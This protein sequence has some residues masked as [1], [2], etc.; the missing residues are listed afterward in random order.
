MKKGGGRKEEEQ[1]SSSSKLFNL[2]TIYFNFLRN[3]VFKLRNKIQDKE[4]TREIKTK[5]IN[6]IL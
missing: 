2:S 6:Q 4:K 5:V 1:N 3:K